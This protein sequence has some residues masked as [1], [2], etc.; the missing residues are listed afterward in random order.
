MKDKFIKKF[1]VLIILLITFFLIPRTTNAQAGDATLYFSPS[2]TAVS[3]NGTISIAVMINTGSHDINTVTADFTYPSSILQVVSIDTTGSEFEV[4]AESDY[5]SGTVYISRGST[6]SFTGIGEVVTVNFR[7][8]S[9]G[10]AT[11]SFTDDAL[12]LDT[13]T[14]DQLGTTSDGT[15]TVS[16]SSLPNTGL[17]DKPL[18][19]LGITIALLFI[20][21]GFAGVMQYKEDLELK[22]NK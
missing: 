12:A 7:G 10:T 1:S 20:T 5:T 6:G 21:L 16:S 2:T 13:D 19:F 11:L 18:F 9:S 3:L 22:G 8:I 14:V 17:Y 4:Q 15:V